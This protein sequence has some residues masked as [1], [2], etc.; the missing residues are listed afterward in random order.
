MIEIIEIIGTIVIPLIYL[1][2][3]IGIVGCMD[4]NANNY[5]PDANEDNGYCSYDVVGCMD[6]TANNYN[7][8]ATTDDGSCTYDI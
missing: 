8:D 4:S 2:G 5:N 3:C 6:T 7:A 1:K